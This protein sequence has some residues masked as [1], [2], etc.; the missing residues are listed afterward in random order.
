M[1]YLEAQPKREPTVKENSEVTS[2]L[3]VGPRSL[4]E[5]PAGPLGRGG[6]QPSGATLRLPERSQ[7]WRAKQKHKAGGGGG[8]LNTHLGP[9]CGSAPGLEGITGCLIPRFKSP[10]HYLQLYGFLN[11]FEPLENE[12]LNTPP[13]GITAG[14]NTYLGSVVPG[15]P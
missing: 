11:H 3:A 12:A 8:F 13:H 10:R 7:A 5:L 6:R 14:R 4:I 2:Q 1:N 15:T 9:A